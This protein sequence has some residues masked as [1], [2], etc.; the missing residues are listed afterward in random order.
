MKYIILLL[1]IFVVTI[2]LII[3]H[4]AIVN[5]NYD[6]NPNIL[7]LNGVIQAGLQQSQYDANPPPPLPRD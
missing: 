2:G 7:W 5:K 3:Y 4:F 1:S 6:Y